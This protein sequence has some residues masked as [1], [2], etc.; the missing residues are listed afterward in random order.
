MH[1]IAETETKAI[2]ATR[3]KYL[4]MIAGIIFNIFLIMGISL[5]VL[6]FFVHDT[7]GYSN[8]IV[9]LVIGIQYAATLFTRQS[10]GKLADTKG[11]KKSI[12]LGLI[13]STVTG[14]LCVIS[15]LLT[16]L[17]LLSLIVLIIA[18]IILGIAESYI[19]IGIFAW[20]F[21][22]V[23][24][25]HIGKVIV[26][27]GMGMYGGLSI[28][29]PLSIYLQGHFSIIT[30][31]TLIILF[32][33]LAYLSMLALPQVK[34]EP[35]E[36]QLSFFKA[37]GLVW[38]SG[39]GLALASIGFG[40]IASFI[41]LYFA[42]QSWDGAS[43]AISAFGIGYI[44]TR[45]F[46]SGY[47]DKFGGAKVALISLIV[48]AIGLLLIWSATSAAM[49]ITGS[50]LTGLGMSLVFP[51]FGLIAVNHVDPSNRGMAIAAYNAFFDIGVG[52]T[53]PVAGLVARNGGYNNIYIMGAVAAAISATLAYAE[54]KKQKKQ[55][56][57]V[58]KNG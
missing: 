41:T 44:G 34:M 26:W 10:A 27:N 37:I 36:H 56:E 58:T 55:P 3:T 19:V 24:K 18:R 5:G 1:T 17:P 31:F 50:L 42:Q 45:I 13:L 11:G 28:G 16:S 2:K 57:F 23:G 4:L 49:G 29:A 52:L 48:E 12:T 32:P 33:I 9:G 51:S 15:V 54:L 43:F 53:A 39:S 8:I 30:P 47:P 7:L 38:K 40:G 35:Q 22:I 46:F 21:K 20:G 25:K 14:V 6:P